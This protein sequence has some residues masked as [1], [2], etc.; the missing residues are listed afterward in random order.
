MSLDS[1]DLLLSEERRRGGEE[2]TG[3]NDAVLVCIW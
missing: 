3:S 1:Y 2:H